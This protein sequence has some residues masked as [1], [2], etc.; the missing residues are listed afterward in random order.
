M[1]RPKHKEKEQLMDQTPEEKNALDTLVC[2]LE[3]HVAEEVRKCWIDPSKFTAQQFLDK[4]I[5]YL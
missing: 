1:K 2:N 3:P 4:G 5:N